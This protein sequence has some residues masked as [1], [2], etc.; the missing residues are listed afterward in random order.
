MPLSHPAPPPL[1]VLLVEDNPDGRESLQLLLTLLG[2]KVTAAADGE[3]GLSVGVNMRPDVAIIDI[4]LPDMD[5]RQVAQRL[6]QKLGEAVRL[7]AYTAYREGEGGRRIAVFDEWVTKPDE[8][9]VLLSCLEHK[10]GVG[11]KSEIGR[12]GEGALAVER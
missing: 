6:R 5:G 3:E 4:N 12:L 10:K 9:P 1:R 7:I 8:L 2:Y 11:S